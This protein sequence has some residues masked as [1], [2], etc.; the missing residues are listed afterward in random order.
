VSSRRRFEGTCDVCGDPISLEYL[1]GD[2]V[3]ITDEGRVYTWRRHY[4]TAP[5]GAN[6]DC[7]RYFSVVYEVPW[8]RVEM[9]SV[10]AGPPEWEPTTNLVGNEFMESSVE[11][12]AQ[13]KIKTPWVDTARRARE[14]SVSQQGSLSGWMA[15]GLG[16][17]G[18]GDAVRIHNG[19]WGKMQTDDPTTVIVGW[20]KI[21]FLPLRLVTTWA[22]DR[23][24]RRLTFR[25]PKLNWLCRTRK[26]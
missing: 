8:P 1:D 6:P 22:N 9:D 24:S 18:D 16:K 2:V 25:Q 7:A 21:R 19:P 4:S 14:W 17:L 10:E 3:G 5:E 12:W 15:G 26:P 23:H 20:R 13:V 11:G